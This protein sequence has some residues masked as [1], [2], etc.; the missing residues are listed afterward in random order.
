MDKSNINHQHVITTAP[1]QMP[2][3]INVTTNS[4]PPVGPKPIDIYCPYCHCR[5]TTRIEHNAT[6]KTHIV[7]VILGCTICCCC[8]PYCIDS[9]RNANHF[10]P[11]CGAYIGTYGS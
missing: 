9:C 11:S 7:A 4:P 1:T 6:T 5:I 8:L 10:C 3:V 2:S